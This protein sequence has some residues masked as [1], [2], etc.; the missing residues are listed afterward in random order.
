MAQR[1]YLLTSPEKF[2]QLHGNGFCNMDLGGNT[3][4]LSPGGQKK[5]AALFLPLENQ[6][7]S[8]WVDTLEDPRLLAKERESRASGSFMETLT[9]PHTFSALE[10]EEVL[11]LWKTLFPPTK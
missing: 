8:R 6:Q 9:K 7:S 1:A 3:G 5:T 4:N 11:S 2:Q 10:R